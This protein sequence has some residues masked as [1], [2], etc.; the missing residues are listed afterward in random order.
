M[1]LLSFVQLE[2]TYAIGPQPGR[3]VVAPEA[4]PT[5]AVDGASEPEAPYLDLTGVTRAA[6]SA[7]G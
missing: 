5:P 1:T 7:D 2:F 3:Y 6:A 4:P